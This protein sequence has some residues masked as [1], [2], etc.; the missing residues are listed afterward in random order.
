M[1]RAYSA[2]SIERKQTYLEV[3]LKGLMLLL[4][5]VLHVNTNGC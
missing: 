4:V 1:E 5:V 3:A 2:T